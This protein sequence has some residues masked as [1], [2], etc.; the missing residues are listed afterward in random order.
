[1]KYRLR[2]VTYKSG[3]QEFIPAY[4]DESPLFSSRWMGLGAAGIAYNH[5]NPS[6]NSREEALEVID[7]HAEGVKE[8]D[9]IVVSTEFEYIT[10]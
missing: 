8:G 4:K 5:I 10:K 9:Y 3:K 2:I 1:M 7:L 6:Y